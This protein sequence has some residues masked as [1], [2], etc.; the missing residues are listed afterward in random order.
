LN[1][2]PQK[3]FWTAPT[4]YVDGTDFGTADFAGYEWG[5]KQ[6]G[7]GGEYNLTVAVSVSF[8]ITELDLSSLALPQL[9]DLDLVMRTVA[10]NGQVSDW[11]NPLPIR[12]DERKPNPPTALAVGA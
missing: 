8:D 10:K 4:K 3:V 9:Q 12:F 7:A 1:L 2:N 6:T 11:T 5:Y